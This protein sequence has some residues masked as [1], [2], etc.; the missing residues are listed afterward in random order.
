MGVIRFGF[1]AALVLTAS[2]CDMWPTRLHDLTFKSIRPANLEELKAENYD[3]PNN[4]LILTFST[5]TDLRAMNQSEEWSSAYL[6]VDLCPQ[7]DDYLIG[8][9][10][11]TDAD[12]RVDD[13]RHKKLPPTLAHG[14]YEYRAF[15]R[16]DLRRRRGSNDRSLDLPL[17]PAPQDL[18]FWVSPSGFS[19]MTFTSATG[20]IP[21]DALAAALVKMMR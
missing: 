4:V 12:G 15:I 20:V 18:C 19:R 16:Y 5:T 1:A 13:K 14:V 8:F 6:A 17:P 21:K 2:A 7:N 9:S 3:L 11:I 10:D